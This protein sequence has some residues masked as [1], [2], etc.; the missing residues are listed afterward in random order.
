MTVPLVMNAPASHWYLCLHHSRPLSSE[1]LDGLEE[2]DHSFIPHPFQDDA[3]SNKH[4]SPPNTSTGKHTLSLLYWNVSLKAS[5][6]RSWQ[7]NRLYTVKNTHT[8]SYLQWTVMGPS[9]P[10]CSLVLCTWPMKSMNPSPVFGTPCS[11]QSVNWNCLMVLDWPSWLICRK[12]EREKK[13]NGSHR[14]IPP[15]PTSWK[16]C[17]SDLQSHSCCC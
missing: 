1:S 8:L 10:N 6:V 4:T 13:I 3:Q 16:E 9:C 7:P 2:V 11:G 17:T 12:M 14:T 15:S 5:H